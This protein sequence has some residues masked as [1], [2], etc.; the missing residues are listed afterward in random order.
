MFLIKILRIIYSKFWCKEIEIS[1]WIS[2]GRGN[3]FNSLLRQQ[4][5]RSTNCCRKFEGQSC[6]AAEDLLNGYDRPE[7]TLHYGLMLHGVHKI[8]ISGWN[9]L[10]SRNS[11]LFRLH[12]T[13][14]FWRFIRYFFATFK[15]LLTRHKKF[16]H[17][18]LGKQLRTS[19]QRL[20]GLLTSEIICH[21]AAKFEITRGEILHDRRNYRSDAQIRF[22]VENLKLLMYQ[23]RIKWKKIQFEA[24]K[25]SKY[26][27]LQ[28]NKASSDL[29]HFMQKSG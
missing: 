29:R 28:S 15:D 22:E 20:N 21:P 10:N 11:K 3:N 8:W 27:L 23:L 17:F 9:S 7:R 19:F 4:I 24:F 16:G 13:S 25:S 26:S 6:S 18:I 2:K 12:S 5:R 14:H 1:I